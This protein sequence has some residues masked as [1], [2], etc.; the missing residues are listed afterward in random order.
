[1]N[2]ISLAF[3][4]FAGK[5]AWYSGRPLVFVFALFIV[6][7]WAILG[8]V[9]GFSDTWQLV[10]N[11]GTTIITFLMVFLVQ[12]S[13][14][15]DSKA[16][17]LKLDELI[18]K[19]HQAD[20][21]MIDIEELSAQQLDDMAKKY[22]ILRE[23]VNSAPSQKVKKEIIGKVFDKNA[24]PKTKKKKEKTSDASTAKTTKK[25]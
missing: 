5:I 18:F 7:T 23:K 17:Q 15:R 4:K 22:K 12:S 9:F 2:R 13:Q 19:M 24:L 20:N 3:E 21:I 10:I 8:P 14:N 11:T 25:A 1:M 6:I 16:L